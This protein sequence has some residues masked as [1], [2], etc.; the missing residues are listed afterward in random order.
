M[1]TIL[2]WTPR[3]LK[4]KPKRLLEDNIRLSP[5]NLRKTMESLWSRLLTKK[6]NVQNIVKHTYF[7]HFSREFKRAHLILTKLGL[8]TVINSTVTT[9]IVF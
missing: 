1:K 5:V 6:K 4:T 3:Q 7:S 2:W 9:V 8:R